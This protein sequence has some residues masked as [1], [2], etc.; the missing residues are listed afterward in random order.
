M[1]VSSY[2]QNGIVYWRVYLDLRGRKNPGA[3]AQKR[4]SAIATEKEA[5]AIER[6]LLR[7]LTEKISF[8]EGLGPKWDELVERW[9]RYQEL[10]P[11]KRYA[12]N[13]IIDYASCVRKWTKPW[14][15][16][17][18]TEITRGD[19]RDIDRQA[20]AAGKS[21]Q[22]RKNLKCIINMIYSWGI[23]ERILPG[24]HHSPVFGLEIEKDR[25][26]KVP[27]ILSREEIRTLI[28]KA[29][30][31]KHPWYPI[32]V[33]AVFTGCRNGELH[34]LR[35]SDVEVISRQ[36][37]ILE[38]EKPFNQRKYGFIRIRRGWNVRE[39]IAGPTKA[40]T[41]RNVPVASE[42]YWFLVHD[43]KIEQMGVND[44]IFQ[45]SWEWDQGMQASI[46]RGFCI[47]NHLP[48]IRFHT[49]R[50]CFATQ[51]IS[52]GIPATVVMKICGWKDMKTMQ[53]YIR[54]AGVDETGAT[55]TLHFIPTEEA[56]M[57]KVVNIYDHRQK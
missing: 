37:A 29:K 51:L 53:R 35:R 52:T 40:G 22:F 9:L 47:A 34:Q 15:N 19:A 56:V 38:D 23:E 16:R 3:R 11:T 41:W 54:L 21:A 1:S 12:K 20:Q 45:R 50:A 8:I 6:Q 25:E 30:E 55:E 36:E 33:G 5:I 28:R 14:A 10:Y 31:Q 24:L 18:A 32:W 39:K 4:I 57:E 13:T 17:P 44:F 7:E 43:I 46:L 49:L 48:S 2:E 27:E 42:F 26:E